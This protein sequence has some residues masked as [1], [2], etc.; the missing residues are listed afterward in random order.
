[1]QA[2][3]E[4]GH[5]LG[6]KFVFLIIS[7]NIAM[8]M[9]G[10]EYIEMNVPLTDTSDMPHQRVADKRGSQS[11]F[12]IRIQGRKPIHFK[13]HHGREARLLKNGVGLLS[14]IVVAIH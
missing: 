13:Q 10:G 4:G 5:S 12:H 9:L 3:Q 7:V 1:M 2:F 8:I 6:T 14:G 11:L